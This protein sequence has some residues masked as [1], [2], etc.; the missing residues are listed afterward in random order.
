M[1]KSFSDVKKQWL[2]DADFRREYDALEDEFNLARTLIEARVASGLTQA[3]VAKRMGITQPTI[4]R[5][6]SGHKPSFKTLERYAEA[7]GARLAIDLL[8]IV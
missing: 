2:K 5:L 3:E 1:N 4:A 7:V 6:E 8:P